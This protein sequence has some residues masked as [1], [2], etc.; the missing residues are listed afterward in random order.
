MP[1]RFQCP[2]EGCPNHKHPYT[3]VLAPPIDVACN[4]K[5]HLKTVGMVQVPIP[6]AERRRIERANKRGIDSE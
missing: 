5:G 6:A 4:A 3:H 2:K 1:V